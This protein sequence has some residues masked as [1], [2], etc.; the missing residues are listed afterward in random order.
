[1]KKTISVES[2]AEIPVIFFI[3]G[4]ETKANSLLEFPSASSG[5]IGVSGSLD[6]KK[7]KFFTLMYFFTVTIKN[8]NS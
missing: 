3:A 1:M 2:P 6:L 7:C 4:G 5:V 8:C